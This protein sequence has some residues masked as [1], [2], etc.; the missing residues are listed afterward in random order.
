MQVSIR[1]NYAQ[2]HW[3]QRFKLY[4]DNGVARIWCEGSQKL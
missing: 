4:S 1:L 2:W 3:Q